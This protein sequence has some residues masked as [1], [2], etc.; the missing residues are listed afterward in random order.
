MSFMSLLFDILRLITAYSSRSTLV[1]L[2]RACRSLHIAF[3]PVLYERIDFSISSSSKPPLPNLLR[4]FLEK[5]YPGQNLSF[6]IRENGALQSLWTIEEQPELKNE[7]LETPSHR[8]VDIN[9]PQ[10]ER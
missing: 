4:R 7:E 6:A 2:Q 3:E 10:P 8:C 9:H 1:A 5:P